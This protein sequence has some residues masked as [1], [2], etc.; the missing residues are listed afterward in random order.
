MVTF[1]K[2]IRPWPPLQSES[3]VL[4]KT[5]LPEACQTA[6]PNSVQEQFAMCPPCIE[7]TEVGNISRAPA[8][9]FAV[10][11]L[12]L[13]PRDARPKEATIEFSAL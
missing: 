13:Q 10:Q 6:P 8:F 5:L 9:V 2:I 4:W 11:S 7:K 3:R 1:P 12:M